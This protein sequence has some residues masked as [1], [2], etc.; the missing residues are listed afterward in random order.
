MAGVTSGE[1]AVPGVCCGRGGEQGGVWAPKQGSPLVA[2]CRLCRWS[3][4]YWRCA[5]NRDN[6][7]PYEPAPPLGE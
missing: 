2:G 6:G 4:S 5:D 1:P 3:S 7:R